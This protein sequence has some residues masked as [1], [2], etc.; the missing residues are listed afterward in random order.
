MKRNKKGKECRTVFPIFSWLY[1][2]KC[3][4]EF[5]REKG[6]VYEYARW[7]EYVCSDCG[8]NPRDA[9]LLHKELYAE[10]KSRRTPPSPTP[11]LKR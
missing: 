1:C 7:R 11:P 5:R 3:K 4:K 2:E 10:K 6:Y 9:Y 8:K